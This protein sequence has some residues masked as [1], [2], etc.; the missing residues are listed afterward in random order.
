MYVTAQG[1]ISAWSSCM[2]GGTCAGSGIGLNDSVGQWVGGAGAEL[3][4]SCGDT[5]NQL[6][7]KS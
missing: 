5:R 4:E 2:G 7:Y 6:I 1:C 3:T